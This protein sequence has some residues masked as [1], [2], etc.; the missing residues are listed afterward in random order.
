MMKLLVTLIFAGTV[1]GAILLTAP[2]LLAGPPIEVELLDAPIVAAQAVEPAAPSLNP[3][4]PMDMLATVVSAVRSGHWRMAAAAIL[5]L[6]MFGF[7]WARKNIGWLKSRLDG[8]RAGAIS[9]IAIALAGGFVAALTSGAPL[10]VAMLVGSLW[11]AVDAA[12]IFLLNKK[13]ISPSDAA[14]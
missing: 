12:G 8:D 6:L 10:D 2:E 7:N 11:T 4:D 1:A 14:A 9:L 5:G 3:D 13:V